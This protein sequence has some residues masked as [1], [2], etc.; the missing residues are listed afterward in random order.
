LAIGAPFGL[1]YTATQGIV[2]AL[3]R[4]LPDD[5]YVPFIQTDVAVNPG[6]SGGPLFDTE[7]RVVGINS[8][9]YSRTGGYM[10]LSF[11]IPINLAVEIADQLKSDGQVRRGWLGVSIQD[12]DQTLAE[13]FGLDRPRGALIAEVQP[14]SPAASSGLEIGDVIMRFDGRE[15]TRSS[16]LPPMVGRVRSDSK[17]PVEVLRNGQEKTLQVTVGELE[18]EVVAA[19]EPAASKGDLGASVAALSKERKAE[20]GE[21]R[22]VRIH[23]TTPDGPASRAGLRPN[24]IL[25]SFNGQDVE[26]PAQLAELLEDAPRDRAVAALILRDEHPRFVGITIAGDSSESG[27]G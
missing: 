1:D 11:A 14:D 23:E 5:N 24:D 2:S 7:G 12:M 8:Q 19:A 25:L 4:S 10:G 18:N 9:I 22:G 20:L 21:Q 3:S 13:S 16:A 27:A 17:V 26:N 15:V 6:N